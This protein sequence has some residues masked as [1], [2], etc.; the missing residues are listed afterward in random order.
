MTIGGVN[1]SRAAAKKT[2]A[3]SGGGDRHE[4]PIGGGK[5]QKTPTT[6]ALTKASA[7]TI[8]VIF[9]VEAQ[10]NFDTRPMQASL[11]RPIR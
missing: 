3:G 10:S 7:M 9:A 1:R 8:A 11:L 5:A 6:I 2:A 4:I